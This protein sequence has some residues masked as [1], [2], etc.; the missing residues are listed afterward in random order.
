MSATGRRGVSSGGK[1][2]AQQEHGLAPL[3][4]DSTLAQVAREY[5][6][7][8]AREDFFSH[9]NPAGENV[10]D[11]VREAGEAFWLVGENIARVTNARQPVSVAVPGWME[12]PRHRRAILREGF[13]TTG[14]GICRGAATYDFTQVFMRPR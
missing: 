11:R 4:P 9:V 10:A 2:T 12:S 13:T 8:M 7:L 6:C 3:A 14:V 1:P 5:S